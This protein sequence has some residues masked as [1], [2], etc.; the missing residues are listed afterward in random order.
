MSNL[1]CIKLTDIWLVERDG[2]DLG[3]IE[4][5]DELRYV[6]S[7]DRETFKSLPRQDLLKIAEFMQEIATA[8]E[9]RGN[10]PIIDKDNPPAD[11]GRDS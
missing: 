4:W 3:T 10:Y 5:W 1:T 2:V 11:P 8:D 7:P 6:H 9:R